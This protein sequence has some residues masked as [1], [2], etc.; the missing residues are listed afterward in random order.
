MWLGL[1]TLAF[2]ACSLYTLRPGHAL[3]WNRLTLGLFLL[4][5]FTAAQTLPLGSMLAAASP[6]VS[7][8]LEATLG[9]GAGALSYE[10]GETSL[11]ATKYCIYAMIASAVA[12]IGRRR[13]T[14]FVLYGVTVGG[15]VSMLLGLVHAIAG[16]PGLFGYWT[17]HEQPRD[18]IATFANANHAAGYFMLAGFTSLGLALESGH[19]RPGFALV[20]GTLFAGSLYQG[21]SGATLALGLGLGLFVVMALRNP[22]EWRSTA[23]ADSPRPRSAR[24]WVVGGA[25]TAATLAV[26]ATAA[27]EAMSSV[28]WSEKA[29]AFVQAP[30]LIADHLWFGVGRG[31]Y[32]SVY[33]GYQTTPLKVSYTHPETLPVQVISE[34]GVVVGAAALIGLLV[35]VFARLRAARDPKNQAVAC[36]VAALVGQN[37]ADFSLELTG[38]LVSV[39]ALLAALPAGRDAPSKRA[40]NPAGQIALTVFV[41]VL[42]WATLVRSA[43]IGD[44]RADLEY[45]EKQL[46]VE[47]TASRGPADA[48]ETRARRHPANAFGW[49]ALAYVL[50]PDDPGATLVAANKAIL[51]APTF[52]FPH[53]L[54]GRVFWMAGFRDQAML[55]FRR[56]WEFTVQQG[57]LGERIVAGVDDPSLVEAALPRDPKDVGRAAL[58]QL[59]R[60][61]QAARRIRGDDYARALVVALPR[62]EGARLADL[63]RLTRTALELDLDELGVAAA[64]ASAE[65][66]E[67]GESDMVRTI[68]LLTRH[69][70]VSEAH[71]LLDQVELGWDGCRMQ[72]LMFLEQGATSSA[73]RALDACTGPEGA[74]SPPADWAE[75]R[76]EI[77]FADGDPKQALSVLAPIV[78]E[79]PRDLSLR[80]KRAEY[81]LALGRTAEARL[82][83]NYVLRRDPENAE[84]K[85]LLD[86]ILRVERTGAR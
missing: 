79:R 41:V 39:V 73:T 9:D 65:H 24:L 59:V 77:A 74:S 14:R 38:V 32:Q 54:A 57:P 6:R 26:G 2:V 20:A 82:E 23:T 10:V 31:S 1:A 7:E 40:L 51:T 62:L 71:D 70:K 19:P 25:V 33:T 56:A 86:Q 12:T 37:F 72:A 81:L 21:S 46:I 18:L 45:F 49:T 27:R 15:M 67:R 11:E 5:L 75:V 58:P 63:R 83:A 53:E 16:W 22:A 61:L 66:P 85:S 17:T 76:A 42:G 60:T 64:R 69:G 13:S 55:E 44:L 29:A 80:R 47:D 30:R 36:G 8:I 4:A 52:A 48:V 78:E 35:A 3:R 68:E 84:V 50:A 34:W 43:R 28:T